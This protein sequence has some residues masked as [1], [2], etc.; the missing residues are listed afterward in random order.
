NLVGYENAFESITAIGHHLAIVRKPGELGRLHCPASSMIVLGVPFLFAVRMSG[1][2]FDVVGKPFF[3]RGQIRAAQASGLAH[4]FDCATDFDQMDC[5]DN[6]CAAAGCDAM[7]RLG[8]LKV[9]VHARSLVDEPG[10]QVLRG[11]RCITRISSQLPCSR[12]GWDLYAH[13]HE[14]AAMLDEVVRV[15][16]AVALD[17]GSAWVVWIRPPIVSFRKEVVWSAGATRRSRSSD[18]D[19]GLAQVLVGGFK[20]SSAFPARYIK[21]APADGK[22]MSRFPASRTK[23]TVLFGVQF[24]GVPRC[25]GE[26]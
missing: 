14:V 26:G 10:P 17:I 2:P 4:H 1:H 9:G 6:T 8:V 21:S 24:R 11:V 15:R 7:D 25:D 18:R 23:G 20:D 12:E 16:H 5:V 3:D 19:W 13:P 22:I